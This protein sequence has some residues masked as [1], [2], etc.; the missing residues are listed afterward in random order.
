MAASAMK[1]MASS[2]AKLEKFE[3]L[4]FRIWQK[5]IHFMLSSMSV[6]Y[7]LTAPMPEDGGENPT[8]EQVRKRA[9]WDNDDYVCRGLIPNGMSDSLFDVYQDVETYKELWDTLEAKYMAKD[10]SNKLPPSWKDFKHTL[11]HL[12]EELT[13]IELGSHLRIE[14]SLRAQDN[15]KPKG[16]NVAGPSVVNMVEHNNSSRYNDNKGK[17]KHHDTRANPN[18]KPKVTCWKC[19]KPGHLKKDCKGGNVGNR[20]NGS[21][22][23][24]SEDGSSNPLK[25]QNR[26]WFMTYESMNDRSILHMGNESTTLVHGRGCVDLSDLCN[27]H[28][29]PLLGNKKY[30]VTFIVDAS[31]FCYVY[32]LHSKD[33]ALDKFKVF[34]TEVELQQGS[35]IKR[36]R[37]DR[38]GEYM[39]TLYFQSVG[40][41]YEM[42]AP[43]TPQQNGFWGEAMLTA[44]YLLNRVP[45][46]RNMITLYEL[47]TKKKSNLNYLKV[48]GCRAVV[49]LPDPK[50]KTLGERGIKCIFVGYAEHS[51]AFRFNVIEP[52]DS[53]AINSIIE[54]RDAIFD[55]HR[56]SYVPRPSQRSL[57]KGTDD[58]GGSLVSK[59][60]TDEI[61]QQ[62]EP[63]KSKRH[64]TPKDF[65]P[66]FQLY[67][68]EGTRDEIFDQ[69]SY[70][71]NVE[72]D[73][74]KF[75][76]AMKS[77]DVTFWK[78]AINDEMNSIM[79][80]NTWVLTDLPPGCR[81]LGCKWIFKRKMKVDGT[82]EKFKARLVIQG[83]KQK[84]EIDYFDTYAPVARIS[85]IRL[86][87]AL[88]SIH[89]LIIHQ[90]DVKT[91]FLNGELKEE[92]YMNQPLGFIFPR[93]ENKVCKLIKSLYGLKQAPKQWNQ[94]FNEVVLS[95]GYLLNQ[96]DKYVYRK[97]DA[98]G[99]GVIICLYV[100]DML[101]FGTD[102]VQVDLTK[103]FLSS[104]FFVK[105]MGEADVI[106]VS[107]PLDTCEKLM[108]NRGL[109]VSQLEYSRVIGCLMYAMTCTRPD[110]A[111]AVGKL[112]RYTSNPSTQHWQ[113]IQRE[114]KYLKKTMDYRLASNKQTCITG[115][116]MES[117][118]V[119]LS[120]AVLLHCKAYSRSVHG[121]KPQTPYC[122]GRSQQNLAD[123]LTKGL[124]RDLVLK[125]A[126]GM[127]LKDLLSYR[128]LGGVRS[129]TPEVPE[130]HSD[131]DYGNQ[132]LMNFTVV[133]SWRSTNHQRNN[134]QQVS[135][136]EF[137]SVLRTMSV[138][139][140]DMQA[141]GSN[142]LLW[143]VITRFQVIS[144]NHSFGDG[145]GIGMDDTS[146]GS[147][148]SKDVMCGTVDGGNE[149]RAAGDSKKVVSPPLVVNTNGHVPADIPAPSVKPSTRVGLGLTH[150]DQKNK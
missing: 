26:C 125:S 44:C 100:D 147:V 107:T 8:V 148:K 28:A 104:K 29:T 123:H 122:F 92:V 117:E 79:G 21:S 81:P 142:S 120:A 53:V 86:L 140:R 88:A 70:C 73:P 41:I 144:G 101:I 34:K 15:D 143:K 36:F 78:E 49:R 16:N 30:F 130:H 80:N 134:P 42:T 67:L 19:G 5:K 43:Y 75:D 141:L 50:L 55:E 51:K 93:N 9:K 39:D 74:K 2:F 114:L 24:G 149:T 40:I 64:R 77:Q 124:A 132:L 14:E 82:V 109:A 112:S 119:A 47:W 60:V 102:Q 4:D 11:K 52:N 3:G 150:S 48:W 118:F 58:S 33:E 145:P 35:L 91:T 127:G 56:F 57:V 61:V 32:L 27:L 23:K 12:K 22:T 69:H 95:N 99:K 87:I 76:K 7:V 1:H 17:R 18:K 108:P 128:Y 89:S 135:S 83:F 111:F 85:T 10:A 68:V 90:M 133:N 137:V 65:G 146:L 63:R 106:L 20:A 59:R 131:S 71:F 45:N 66:E 110:I 121:S 62:S 31:R 116:T 13:L 126:K 139:I 84:L 97:F 25:G 96:A 6:V 129:S 46:K 38:G 94:K 72:D 113:A 98:S 103:E 105:D 138:D 136:T 54:S 115:S 37:T